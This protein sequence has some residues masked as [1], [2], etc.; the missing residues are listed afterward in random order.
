MTTKLQP[1]VSYFRESGL[2]TA[3]AAR[4][5]FGDTITLKDAAI[6]DEVFLATKMGTARYGIVPIENTLT[7][8][9]YEN[10]DLLVKHNLHIIGE[11][12]LRVEYSLLAKGPLKNRAEE[13]ATNAIQ[14]VYSYPK[15]F[16][17]CSIFL[18]ERPWIETFDT[19]DV[20]VAA[21]HVSESQNK[22][23]AIIANKDSAKL[24]HLEVVKESIENNKYNYTRFLIISN[25]ETKS[26][27][28]AN[29]CSVVISLPH[30]SGSLSNVL[31]LLAQHGCNL[32]KIESR[33]LESRSFEYM[34]YLDFIFD[35]AHGLKPILEHLSSIT[36]DT[37]IL[38]MYMDERTKL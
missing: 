11:V 22:Q 20:A 4:R 21:K 25:K 16:E 14:K 18:K 5:Y 6:F 38:G 1:I 2:P 36:T 10:Y 32:T 34:F 27:L 23:L 13:D 8:S 28:V 15:A 30:V 29:K 12:S 3:Q 17:Q 31:A 35:Y 26:P 24:Y 19:P 37:H 33:P 7:G 9:L